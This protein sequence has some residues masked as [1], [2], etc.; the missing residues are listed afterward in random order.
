MRTIK[1]ILKE[2][3]PLMGT[4]NPAEREKLDAL[5]AE[6]NNRELTE[7]EKDMSA[8]RMAVYAAQ[9]YCVDYNVGRLLSHLR[10]AGKLDNTLVFFLADNGACAEPYKE[11]GGGRQEDINNPAMSGSISYGRAWAQISNTPFRKYKCRSYEG[12]ISTPLIVSWNDK[13]GDRKGEWCRVPGYLP[14]IMPTIIEA[15]S[16]TYPSTYHG[17]KIH[18]LVGTS[19][20]PAIEGKTN[21]LHEYMYWEHQNNRAIRQGNWKAV[22]DETGGPWEL[23]NIAED[24]SERINLASEHPELLKELVEEWEHWAKTH[25]VLPK[26]MAKKDAGNK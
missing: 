3:K 2:M 11:L 15:A 22:R 6:L 10:K 9:V 17:H 19:L 13:L 20:F 26:R 18:P 25:Y 12:G 21:S 5:T 24:R 4:D 7:E 14:D 8:Y 1:D 16:A 23:Y